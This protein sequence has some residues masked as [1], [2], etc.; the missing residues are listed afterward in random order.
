[1][2]GAIISGAVGVGSMLVNAISGSRAAKRAEARIAQEKKD[3]EDWYNRRYNE[4]ATQRA[5]AQRVI[6]QTND[7][8]KRR[9]K[10]AQGTQ[11]VMGGTDASTAETQ[12]ANANGMANA[13]S[14]IAATGDAR[15][16]KI[17][18]EYLATKKQLNNEQNAVDEN[19]AANIASAAQ[20]G[21]A[22]AASI[23]S[24]LDDDKKAT[25]GV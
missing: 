1:M 6:T 16:D 11:A 7:A 17:E 22:T 19:K 18:G 10:A 14:A 21:L 4:D 23:A 20:T 24:S 25:K 9:N 3:N 8:I 2:L 13:I 12:Q 5:D 15:K